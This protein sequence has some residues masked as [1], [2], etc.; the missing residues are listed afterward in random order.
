MIYFHFL[1]YWTIIYSTNTDSISVSENSSLQI[2]KSEKNSHSTKLIRSSSIQAMKPERNAPLYSSE[3]ND[4][5]G[6]KK[7]SQST[8]ADILLRKS[9]TENASRR[10]SIPLKATKAE[11]SHLKNLVSSALKADMKENAKIAAPVTNVLQEDHEYEDDFEVSFCSLFFWNKLVLK[12]SFI[13]WSFF[14]ESTIKVSQLC[15]NH[16]LMIYIRLTFPLCVLFTFGIRDSI[17]FR[18]FCIEKKKKKSFGSEW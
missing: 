2:Q 3:H 17:V 8:P 6:T 15:D 13:L 1:V 11:S 16:W 4:K 5:I 10:P 7:A 14:H 12:S 18:S 9:V